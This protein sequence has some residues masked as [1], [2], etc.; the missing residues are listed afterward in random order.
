MR[1]GSVIGLS[2]VLLALGCGKEEVRVYS[3]PKTADTRPA[4]AAAPVESIPVESPTAGAGAGEAGERQGSPKVPWTVPSGWQSRPNASGMRLA[5]YGVT[6]A[7]G[8][9]VDISVVALGENAGSE[10][11]NVNRWRA[12]LKLEPL[13]EEQLDGARD[14]VRVGGEPGFLYDSVST[15]PI[16]DGKYR[17]RTLATLLPAGQ[18]TVFFKATGEADLVAAEKLNFIAWLASV[19]TG[20]EGGEAERPASRP[21]ATAS[22]SGA[23]GAPAAAPL[24]PPGPAA[25]L[26]GW[27]APAHW[28]V[29]GPR[30]MRLASFEIPG[31][32]GAVGDVSISALSSAG[33]GLLANV[34][35][36]RGQV[37]MAPTDDETLVK[38]AKT[39][40]LSKGQKATVVDLG[41]RGPNRIL[42]AIVPHGDKSWFFKLTGPDALVVKERENFLGWIQSI[43]L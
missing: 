37:G 11:E 41:G 12:Q 42:G 30:T 2:V 34:N 20:P 32:G 21:P 7:D 35:R 9:S 1:S 10:L 13:T 24:V 28:K 14:P 36:W 25:D 27:K 16:L 26:P 19:K 29:G 23:P 3:A 17:S 31:E 33:G 6:T 43:V 38:E 22:D 5:S 18:M 4:V 40:T 39:L 15:T 8:R